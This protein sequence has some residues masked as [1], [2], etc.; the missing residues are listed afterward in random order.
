MI[1]PFPSDFDP[2][3]APLLVTDTREQTPLQFT[4]L[5]SEVRGL[6]TGDYSIRHLETRF[7]IER[8]SIA[9]LVGCCTGA[10]RER[11][12]AELVRLRG[13]EFRRLLIVGHES[14]ISTGGYRSRIA[15]RAVFASLNAWQM[16]F[17]VPFVFSPSPE[18]AAS[19][20]ETWAAWFW[21][22]RLKELESMTRAPRI[23]DAFACAGVSALTERPV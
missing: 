8:K 10:N 6:P 11:F 5:A 22:E 3:R 16:R 9:D 20:V 23:K 4:R 1:D 12:E 14:D 21:R 15:P 18:T 17:D 7:A 19:Q 2:E 13:Y